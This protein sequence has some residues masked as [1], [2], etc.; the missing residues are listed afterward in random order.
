MSGGGSARGEPAR[1][2]AARDRD[3]PLPPP[4]TSTRQLA[5]SLDSL[6]G[7]RSFVSEWAAAERLDRGRTDELVLA[8]N[9]LATNSVRYGGGRG[10]LYVWREGETLL[11]EVR[12][13]GHI[14]DPRAGSTLPGPDQFSGR[15]L[16][17]V[18]NLCE[19]VEIH[20]S[21]QGT[22]VRVH[23]QLA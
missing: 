4:R 3:A 14:E 2:W 23:K 6:H 15:G 5:F 7:M 10:D 19:L 11:C 21:D 18:N 9:E 12:D 20:S 13:R 22:A 1:G 8:V 16:W 17:L